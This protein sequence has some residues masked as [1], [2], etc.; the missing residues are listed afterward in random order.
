MSTVVKNIPLLGNYR[1][2][3][4]HTNLRQVKRLLMGQ[5]LSIFKDELGTLNDFYDM[6][7][8]DLIPEASQRLVRYC[9]TNF[10][11]SKEIWF[12]DGT[13]SNEI[14]LPRRNIIYVNAVFLRFLPN[15]IWYRFVRPRLIDGQEFEAIGGVEPP[16]PGPE[17][18]PPDLIGTTYTQSVQDMLYTGTEDADLY[19]DPRRRTII[20]P[21][22]VLYAN[23]QSPLW[24]YTFFNATMNVEV[25]YA[26]G[27]APTAYLDGSP[28]Q[29]DSMG[30][31]IMTTPVTQD[32]CGGQ[33]VDWSSG[34]PK[35]LTQLCARL[36]ACDIL[37]RLW[38]AKTGGLSSISV[39]GASESYGNAPFGGDVDREEERVFKLLNTWAI[40]MV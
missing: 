23:V 10:D 8:E 32:G 20:I 37:R 19:V 26:Y 9:R 6:I 2:P 39:D 25:H 14:Q 11:Y 15:Q 29:F 1:K 3:L 7:V 34:M 31:L 35:E 17:S 21:P 40:G 24:D 33:G 12:F 36:V 30:N 5:N 4:A 22:R 38:R 13:G 28:L 27:F 16:P 18:I